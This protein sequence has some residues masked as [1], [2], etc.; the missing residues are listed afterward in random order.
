MIWKHNKAGAKRDIAT[1]IAGLYS[2]DA[3]KGARI[4]R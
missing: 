2:Q 4:A 1:E 3:L